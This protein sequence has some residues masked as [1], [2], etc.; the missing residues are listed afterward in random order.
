MDSSGKSA[1]RATFYRKRK[2]E[3][4]SKKN[5]S[6]PFSLYHKQI[7]QK[8]FIDQDVLVAHNTYV[9]RA[10]FRDEKDIERTIMYL[11]ASML[12]LQT[13]SECLRIFERTGFEEMFRLRPCEVDA[14]RVHEILTTLE[15]DGTCRLTDDQGEHVLVN[16]SSE[17]VV[18]A[19]RL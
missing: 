18:R 6:G 12:P 7:V 4:T 10:N 13:S 1:S 15:E 14:R 5:T 9:I 17:T 16:I 19:L 11:A 8:C 2:Q 3:V